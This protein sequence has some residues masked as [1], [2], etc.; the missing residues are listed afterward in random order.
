MRAPAVRL[1]VVAA[2]LSG[3][4][5]WAQRP[6]LRTS[7]AARGA[8]PVFRSAPSG[9]SFMP[10]RGSAQPARGFMAA[11]QMRVF[12]QGRASG[13]RSP[14][15]GAP[16]RSIS[17]I[18]QPQPNR[19]VIFFPPWW[20]YSNPYG[21]YGSP[22]SSLYNPY[23]DYGPSMWNGIGAGYGAQNYLQN[24]TEDSQAPSYLDYENS[25]P[26]PPPSAA[27]A[28]LMRRQ[29][30]TSL[31]GVDLSPADASAPLVIGSGI[32]TLRIS[33]GTTP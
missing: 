3:V 30:V 31:D 6:A 28:R 10:M 13:V 17:S 16:G 23:F 4:Q 27:D 7:S 19:R 32:H 22:Y 21:L 1:F 12:R 18:L 24:Q 11:R 26:P 14:W 8:A 5:V 2:L 9:R 20:L 15:P 25:N 33:A 29:A